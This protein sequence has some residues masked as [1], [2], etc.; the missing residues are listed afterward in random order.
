MS[1]FDDIGDVADDVADVVVDVVEGVAGAVGDAVDWVTEA[2][3]DA[4]EWGAEAVVDAAVWAGEATLDSTDF[5]LTTLD[6]SGFFDVVDGVT[7]GLI[8]LDYEDG[9][10]SAQIGIE[11]VFGV[12]L[13]VSEDGFGLDVD[14]VVA[15]Y[16]VTVDDDGF[17]MAGSLGMDWGPLPYAEAHV[18]VDENANFGLGGEVH[19]YIP[20]PAGVMVGGEV[21]GDFQQTDDGYRV[22]GSLTGGSYAATGTYAKGGVH[23]SYEEDAD[24]YRTVIGIHGEVGQVGAGSV[25]GS[26]DYVDGRDGDIRTEGVFASGSVATEYGGEV[27]GTVGYQHIETPDGD[28][29]VVTGEVDAS[30][31][32][33]SASAN[34]GVV[35][36]PDG[37]VAAFGDADVEWSDD[38]L[39]VIGTAA[40]LAG[41]GSS[42][43]P[44]IADATDLLD[45]ATDY[46]GDPTGSLGDAVG[47]EAGGDPGN[48]V[49]HGEETSTTY[50][51][52]STGYDGYE[53]TDETV[54]TPADQVVESF[55]DAAAPAGA[56]DPTAD[57]LGSLDDLNDS[58]GG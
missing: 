49:P 5:F 19:L 52:D 26:I 1:I 46:L 42:A 28:F 20:T 34:A 18:S 31:G 44:G 16:E 8:D 50:T 41:V 56:P 6:D 48:V 22:S 9:G 3:A 17:G 7:V 30:Y 15:G 58:L 40:D 47:D 37:D 21:A 24:G 12:G 51:D 36:G 29:D 38:P 55:E 23:A 25:K 27:S 33:Q 32:G 10:F 53:Y 39:T 54:A 2:A 14:Y 4:A 35:V 13:D 45:D 11:D 43:I 57:L